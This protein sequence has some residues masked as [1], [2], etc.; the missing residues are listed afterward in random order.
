MATTGDADS[1]RVMTRNDDQHDFPPLSA[2]DPVKDWKR[3]KRDLM[4]NLQSQTDESGTNLMEHLYDRDMGGGAI[5]APPMPA[6]GGAA[7]LKM[8]RLRPKRA[9]TAY[10]TI[11]KHLESSDLKATAAETYQVPVNATGLYNYLEGLYDRPITRAELRT[12]DREWDELSIVNDVGVEKESIAKFVT[13]ME[14]LNGDRPAA[15]R[16]N[17][18]ERAEKLLEAIMDASQHFHVSGISWLPSHTRSHMAA[19]FVCQWV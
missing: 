2:V 12:L 9:N 19:V 13:R 6:G 17:E 8:Q 10:S 15:E 4:A 11:Y 7:A 5:G 18:T 1:G 3:W 16:K 14:R